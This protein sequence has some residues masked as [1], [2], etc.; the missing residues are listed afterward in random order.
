M[1]EEK[2]EKEKIGLGE[3]L[4]KNIIVALI[5]ALV[6]GLL[7]GILIMYFGR[8]ELIARANGKNITSTQL[9]N[10]I[11][12]NYPIEGVLEEVDGAIL[13]NKYKLEKEEIE[14]IKDE[15]EKYISNAA[16]YGYTES[17]FL[18]SNGFK[19]K[20]DFVNYLALYY[21]RNIYYYEYLE[22]LLDE[23]AV[24]Q[25]YDENAFGTVS[26]KH[27]LVKTGTES[28]TDEEALALAKKI[29]ERLDAGEDFDVLAFEYT[30]NYPDY[31][32]TEDLGDNTAFSHLEQGYLDGMKEL[33][34]KE[35]SKEPVQTSYG[36]HVIYCVDRTEK[37]DKISR[38][39]RMEI[40]DKLS[41]SVLEE[42]PN[43]YYD[44]MTKLR[45]DAGLKIFDS[46]FKEKYEDYLSELQS[47][48]L[49]SD[50]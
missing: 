8:G 13:N 25:Y 4:K 34:A 46:F 33:N 27:I 5:C 22:K 1:E 31:V 28:A 32:I 15:V 3:W 49:Q 47:S 35:H 20:D 50:E 14:E 19:T 10:K 44:A 7:I 17:D 18:E 40:I 37:T 42:N 26:T 30:Q 21:K 45:E 41:E 48:E 12:N 38:M 9:F 29:I 2:V 36:Y 23:N 6:L 11:K 43:A 24:Q 16:S 39:D